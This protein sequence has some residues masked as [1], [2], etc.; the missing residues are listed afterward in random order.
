MRTENQLKMLFQK[1][2]D[3]IRVSDLEKSRTLEL[4]TGWADSGK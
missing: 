4:L 1:A 2:K 3:E